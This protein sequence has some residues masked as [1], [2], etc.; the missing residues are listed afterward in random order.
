MSQSALRPAPGRLP[1]KVGSVSRRGTIIARL[2]V[3]FLLLVSMPLLMTGTALNQRYDPEPLVPAPPDRLVFFDPQPQACAQ[4]AGCLLELPHNT[5]PAAL[6]VPR[7]AHLP[8]VAARTLL[9]ASNRWLLAAGGGI[10]GAGAL[11]SAAPRVGQPPRTDSLPFM[12]LAHADRLPVAG[13][14]LIG[15]AL[16]L[17]GTALGLTVRSPSE[18]FTPQAEPWIPGSKVLPCLVASPVSPAHLRSRS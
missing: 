2:T 3:I 5:L 18:P 11:R 6:A 10:A 16:L 14:F 1:G 12:M 4:D 13:M 17:A 7:R 9:P 8:S 15:V